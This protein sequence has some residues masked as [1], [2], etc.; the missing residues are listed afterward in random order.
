MARS[1]QAGVGEIF[2]SQE[3]DK[4]LARKLKKEGL[5][6]FIDNLNCSKNANNCKYF[7]ACDES[8]NLR[9]SCGNLKRKRI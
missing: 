1:M 3:M 5:G 6:R 7:K 4:A 9:C 2:T 8:N